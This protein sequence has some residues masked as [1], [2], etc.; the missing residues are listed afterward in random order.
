MG[1]SYMLRITAFLNMLLKAYLENNAAIANLLIHEKKWT[2]M[3]EP[4]R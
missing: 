3:Q 4:T 2:I 1:Q